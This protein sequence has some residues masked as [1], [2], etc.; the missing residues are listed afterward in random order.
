MKCWHKWHI[1]YTGKDLLRKCLKCGKTQ[2]CH[3]DRGIFLIFRDCTE[4]YYANVIK[5][6]GGDWG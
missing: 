4:K 5:D 2:N 1:R 3:I 6:Y